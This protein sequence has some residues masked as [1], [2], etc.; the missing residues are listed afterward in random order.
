MKEFKKN[1]EGYFICE[2]CSR[3]FKTLNGLAKHIY[4]SH[5]GREEYYEKWLRDQNDVCICCGKETKFKNFSDGCAN[6]CSVKCEK[7]LREKTNLIK[8]GVKYPL[9]NNKIKKKVQNTCLKKYGEKSFLTT[10]ECKEA[11]FKKYDANKNIFDSVEI[12]DKIKKTNLIKY[13]VENVSLD[14][15]IKKKKEKTCLSNYGVSAG[16]NLA[17]KTK[18]TNIKKYGVPYPTQN[19]EIF[20]KGQKTRFKR[21]KF[22]NTSITYQG[23]YELDFLEKFYDKLDIEN[24]PSIDYL[25]EGKK[26]VYHSDFYIPSKNL[27]VEIKNSYLFN[28]GKPIIKAKEEFTIKKGYNYVLIIDKN[29]E[30]INDLI[31]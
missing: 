23:S 24:G 4:F 20:E 30:K 19:K 10:K 9:Q 2:E 15:N 16:F 17:D 26:H 8:Y 28:T 29:Y 1:Q 11:C 21:E 7:V 3:V 27:V 5:F 6:T 31:A 14:Q 12:R 13:G 22:K 18:K 25:F